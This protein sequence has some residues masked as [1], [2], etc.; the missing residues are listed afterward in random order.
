MP[1]NLEKQKER[2]KNH[3]AKFTDYGNIKILDYK[4]P[5]SCE[6]RIRFLFEEDYHRLHISGDLGE[7]IA[8]NYYNMRFDKF[9][10][11]L[12]DPDYFAEKIDCMNRSRYVYDEDLAR[13]DLRERIENEDKKA[14]IL[15]DWDD[16]ENYIDNVLRDFDDCIGIGSKGRDEIDNIFQ[17]SFELVGDI[18]KES[19][20][21]IELYL[22]A[23]E[24]A[25]KD[26][27]SRRKDNGENDDTGNY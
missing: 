24:L 5:K 18:G 1:I 10:D 13:Q 12:G 11:F 9:A 25:M 14:E 7:L 2:F 17:D 26:L 3:V 21:I 20:G 16:V 19:T 23:F 22:M 6:Y 4:N 8:T 27:R 15:W